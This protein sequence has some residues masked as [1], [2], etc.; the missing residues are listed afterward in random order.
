MKLHPNSITCDCCGKETLPENIEPMYHLPDMVFERRQ[1]N[2]TV[3]DIITEDFIDFK[4]HCYIRGLMGVPVNGRAEPMQI[5]IWVEVEQKDFYDYISNVKSRTRQK[6]NGRLANVIPNYPELREV[7][8]VLFD[9]SSTTR[10]SVTIK[11]ED[12]PLGQL[13]RV[14][15]K[16]HDIIDFFDNKK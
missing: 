13:Q 2:H 3:G 10:P 12:S 11:E 7:E 8:V 15:I 9:H 5:G 16:E 14:G 6:F 4:N 1:E